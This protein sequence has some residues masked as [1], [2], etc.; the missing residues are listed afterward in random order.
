MLHGRAIHNPRIHAGL[1]GIW[2]IWLHF[3]AGDFSLKSSALKAVITRRVVKDL[4]RDMFESTSQSPT[5]K[6]V[7]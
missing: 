6:S 3:T 1:R 4:T 7:T 2:C 5:Q